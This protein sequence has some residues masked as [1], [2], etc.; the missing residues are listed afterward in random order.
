MA[1]VTIPWG[2]ENLT[3]KLPAEWTVRQV[4]RPA[5]APAGAD[6]ADHLAAALAKPEEELPLA[7]L[8]AA[9]K[10]GRISVIVEDVTR[11]SPL[12]NILPIIFRELEYAKIPNENVEIVFAVGQHPAL[13]ADEAVAKLGA[14]LAGEFRWRSNPWHD[15]SAFLSLGTVGAPGAGRVDLAIDRRVAQADLRII[16]TS[17]SPH[18]QAGFGGGYKMLLP[19][20]AARESIRQMH[21]AGV[22]RSRRQQVGQDVGTN[23]MRRIIDAAGAAVDK[24]AGKS[25]GVQ[26]LLDARDQVSAIACGDV[27]VCHQL[28][29]KKCAA[30]YGVVIDAPADVVITNAYP[31]DFDLW[32]SFKGIANTVAAARPNGVVI[33]LTRCPAGVNKMPIRDL[34]VSPMFVRNV[35]RLIGA[36]T[37]GGLLTR[38]VP[39]FAGDAAFFVR[40]AA[41]M[42]QRNVVLMVSPTLA[43]AGAKM[44]GLP[45]FATPEEA[46]A[47]AN[48][49]LAPGEKSVVVF[50]AGGVTY[51]IMRK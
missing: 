34:P 50:P 24:A 28:L 19:G 45:L 32:Q 40:L 7:K 16:V 14:K 39:Q 31:R 26:Y 44:L 5:I 38:L 20:C 22:E 42:I 29:A 6:W 43:A 2:D 33:C 21:M 11:H 3:V 37:V 46:F 10:N 23:K 1:D 17:V 18:L 47:K 27:A 4:A 36:D 51:P 8:L 49:L 48:E 15:K 25:F 13:T 9:R 35:I 30:A 41:R 12:E